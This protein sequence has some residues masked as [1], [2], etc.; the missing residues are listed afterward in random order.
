MIHHLKL[1]V[2]LF[3]LLIPTLAIQDRSSCESESRSS[4]AASSSSEEH[5]GGHHPHR[6]RTTTP[7]PHPHCEEGWYTSYRPQ[8]IWCM[9]VSL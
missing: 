8:G 4:S 7:K 2:T 1:F 5:H 6:P 9:K 3:T